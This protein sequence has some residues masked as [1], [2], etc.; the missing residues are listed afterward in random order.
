ME[1][2]KLWRGPK[3]H[4]AGVKQLCDYLDIHDLDKGYLVVFNF[5][6]TYKISD[7]DMVAYSCEELSRSFIPNKEFK[8][9]RIKS[10]GKDIFGVYV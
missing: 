3:S 1:K 6:Q 5:K 10:E 4:E 9:E 7:F 2:M 8:E